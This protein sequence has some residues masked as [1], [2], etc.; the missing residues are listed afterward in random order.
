MVLI[1]DRLN[2]GAPKEALPLIDA[3]LARTPGDQGL[4]LVRLATLEQLGDQP[5]S[6]AELERMA[7]LFPDDLGVRQALVQ[8]HLRAGDP[9]GAEAVLRAAAARDRP[10][11]R[12]RR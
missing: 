2:A 12:S 5:G 3:A 7:A 1:A 8:W 10:P 11:T 6:G 9:A 4:H